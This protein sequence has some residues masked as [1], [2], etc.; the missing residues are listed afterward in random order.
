MSGGMSG[1]SGMS[2]GMSGMSGMSG[3]MSGGIDLEDKT[4]PPPASQAEMACAGVGPGSICQVES[5]EGVCVQPGGKGIPWCDLEECSCDHTLSC[6]MEDVPWV[7]CCP[8][9]ENDVCKY[10]FPAHPDEVYEGR[11]I[12][13]DGHLSCDTEAPP[14]EAPTDAPTEAPTESPGAWKPGR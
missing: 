3:G 5:K 13:R 8:R 10:F 9:A 11:C 14:T 7:A 2:G 12:S 4:T 1:M 6:S